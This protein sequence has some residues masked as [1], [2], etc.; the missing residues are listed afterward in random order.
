IFLTKNTSIFQISAVSVEYDE[1]ATALDLAKELGIDLDL[2]FGKNLGLELGEDGTM[3]IDEYGILDKMVSAII[4]ESKAL[5]KEIILLT[6]RQLLK[7]FLYPVRQ[8]EQI[9]EDI[10][11]RAVESEECVARETVHI[12]NIVEDTTLEFMGCGRDAAVTSI[13][14]ILDTKRAVFQLTLDGYQLAKLKRKCNSYKTEVMQN[15]CKVKLGVKC[16]L[17]VFEGQK[18]LRHL[19]GLRKSVPAVATDATS[20]TNAATAHAVQGL[21]D[22][23]ASINTCINTMF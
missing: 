17:F 14:I 22:I 5:A 16:G 7:I 11:R 15:S 9:V 12:A 19:I 2:E 20:C 4:A 10:E 6:E 13:N 23:N 8:L 3:A 18:S 1:D 21:D